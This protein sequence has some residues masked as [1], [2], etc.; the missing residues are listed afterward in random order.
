M[1]R[2]TRQTDYAILLLAY[3]AA[4]DRKTLQ[5][6]RALAEWSGLS[7]PMVAKILK[8]L[9]KSGIIQSQR[10]AKGGHMLIR[11]ADRITVGEIIEATEG[12]I[13]MTP[14][15]AGTGACEQESI[16]RSKVKWERIGD[17]V[18]DA[19][20]QVLLSDMIGPVIHPS[21]APEKDSKTAENLLTI[22]SQVS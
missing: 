12:P 4:G 21:C 15:T 6:S 14:C 5:T 1:I 18:R 9:A 20:N 2:I 13:H 7:M 8:P 11:P 19:V 17:A 3:M 16:C 22:Q 10:G